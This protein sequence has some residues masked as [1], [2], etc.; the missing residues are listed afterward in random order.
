M[1]ENS[2]ILDKI[3]LYSKGKMRLEEKLAF[4]NEL[5]TDEA[6]REQFE[7]SQ[8]VDQMIIGN[9]TLKLK[10]QMQKDLYNTKPK[11]GS[12]L[13]VSLFALVASA[14]LFM[15]F[16]IKNEKSQIEKSV[17]VVPKITKQVERQTETQK[18]TVPTSNKKAMS[19]EKKTSV[20]AATKSPEFKTVA[21]E[22]KEVQSVSVPV[23]AQIVSSPNATSKQSV[24]LPIKTTP[25]VDLTGKVETPVE[26]AP[27]M[28]ESKKQQASYV[29]NPEYDSS[30]PIPFDADKQA[31]SINILEKGGKVFFQSSV[32]ASYPTEWKGESNTGLVLG[33]GLYFFTIEYADGSVDEGS[34][35]VTR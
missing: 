5:A 18:S 30:W 20:E 11:W 25:N 17:V 4:E 23:S 1:K 2:D 13:A 19:Q 9:E 6:L 33:L 32:S 29:Y 16:N 10:E 27:K 3:E 28:V 8:I 21:I 35:V 31:T 34:I 14:G 26:H 22:P 24:T 12:Y 7:F 15:V